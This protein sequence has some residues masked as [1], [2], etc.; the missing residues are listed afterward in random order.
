MDPLGFSLENFDALGKWRTTTD[1]SPIDASASLPDGS[2]FDGVTGLR[3]LLLNHREDFVRTFTD[4]LLSYSIGR[5]TEPADWPA[6]RKIVRDT[7]SEDHR[8]SSIIMA[9]VESTPFG[10]ST[11]AAAP[12]EVRAGSSP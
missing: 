5:G 12:L 7:A 2:H 8:W 11:S 3:S 10:M 4:R 6:V 1:G 9:I